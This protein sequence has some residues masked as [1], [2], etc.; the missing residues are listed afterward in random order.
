MFKYEKNICFDS[1]S[2]TNV[3]IFHHVSTE[4]SVYCINISMH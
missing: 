1:V 4:W 3:T 2:T